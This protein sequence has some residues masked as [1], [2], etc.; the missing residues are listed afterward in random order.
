M[1]F[2]FVSNDLLRRSVSKVIS[3]EKVKTENILKILSHMP[4]YSRNNDKTEDIT[5]F[6]YYR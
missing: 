4:L 1:F 5:T 3:D 6:A 2:F